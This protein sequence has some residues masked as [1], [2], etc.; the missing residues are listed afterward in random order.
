MRAETISADQ[1]IRFVIFLQHRPRAGQINARQILRPFF[2]E[3]FVEVIAQIEDVIRGDEAFPRQDINRVGDR[4]RI[5]QVASAG[6]ATIVCKLRKRALEDIRRRRETGSLCF[7]QEMRRVNG[8]EIRFRDWSPPT[9]SRTRPDRFAV[10]ATSRIPFRAARSPRPGL[11]R[12]RL[13]PRERGG[14]KQRW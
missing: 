8:N 10:G 3:L 11:I 5:G 2:G 12:N 9:S 1:T 6:R 14:R 13:H 4:A 7:T